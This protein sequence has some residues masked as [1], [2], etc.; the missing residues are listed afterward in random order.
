M[1]VGDLHAL[2]M[3]IE[4]ATPH[5]N[6]YD[7]KRGDIISKYCSEEGGKTTPKPECVSAL[8]EEMKALL[9]IDIDA[10]SY[11]HLPSRRGRVRCECMLR[12]RM[13]RRRV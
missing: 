1:A 6:F 13:L 11:T 12:F 3:L 5:L 4:K 8:E 10:V 9:D 2:H 7:E